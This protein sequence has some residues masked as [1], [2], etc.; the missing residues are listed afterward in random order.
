M[1]AD[2]YAADDYL[3]GNRSEPLTR[4]CVAICLTADAQPDVLL[5]I[6]VQINVLNMAPE[7]VA[8]KKTADTVTIEIVMSGVSEQ[9]VNLVC[10]K[11]GQLT[12]VLDVSANAVT[13]L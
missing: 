11:L 10:R 13:P 5:R 3:S 7:R 8:L 2:V 12:C 9:A 1:T 6:A 4:D